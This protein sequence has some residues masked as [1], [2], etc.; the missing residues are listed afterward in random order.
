MESVIISVIGM[1]TDRQA[2]S[3]ARGFFP[4]SKIRLVLGS[5]SSSRNHARS[6]PDD[7]RLSLPVCL[8]LTKNEMLILNLL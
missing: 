8:C 5:L 1:R 2:D 4:A 7:F 6:P 3:S